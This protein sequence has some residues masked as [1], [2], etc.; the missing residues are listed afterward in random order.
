MLI[1]ALRGEDPAG[2][3]TLKVKDQGKPD[4]N[5]S[6]IGWDMKFWGA[7]IDPA[8]AHLFE[9]EEED[10]TFPPKQKPL[11]PSG[12]TTNTYSKPTDHLPADHGHAEGENTKPAFP[13][14]S[15]TLAND[16]ESA[17]ATNHPTADEGYFSELSNL[18]SN[19][20]WFFGAMFLVAVFG[21]GAAV[22][23]WRRRVARLRRAEYSTL[24]QG[25]GEMVNL[26]SRAPASRGARELYDAFGENSDDEADEE[27][28]LRP[29]HQSSRMPGLGFHSGFLDD[30]EASAGPR[31]AAT[32]AYKD[33]PDRRPSRA[34]S[35]NGRSSGDGSWE[36][37]S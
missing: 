33:E 7:A 10:L 27:T 18:V 20:K 25:E 30:D 35:P 23:F 9:Y 32:T 17:S 1:S 26:A 37:A 24:G 31:T 16:I 28:G 12:S 2:I 8:K 11:T 14:G 15:T 22:F 36:H 4:I 29:H 3:W 34:P 5:G 6:F 13:Q 21:V 19:Q